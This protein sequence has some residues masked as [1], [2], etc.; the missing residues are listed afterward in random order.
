DGSLVRVFRTDPMDWSVHSDWLAKDSPRRIEE[1]IKFENETLMPKN[2]LQSAGLSG[3]IGL[4]ESFRTLQDLRFGTLMAH[5]KNTHGISAGEALDVTLA[6][7]PAALGMLSCK[8]LLVPSWGNLQCP[9]EHTVAVFPSTQA[10]LIRNPYFL[11]RFRI[12]QSVKS[13]PKIGNFSDWLSEKENQKVV[14][15]LVSFAKNHRLG[16][17][18][19]ADGDSFAWE[20]RPPEDSWESG[21]IKII[22]ETNTSIELQVESGGGL[23]VIA[24]AYD[25]DWEAYRLDDQGSS[26]RLP[27]YRANFVMR[28]IPLPSGTVT[29]RMTY[30]PR[31]IYWGAGVS[32]LGFLMA[33]GCLGI[34]RNLS[35]RGSPSS[36]EKVPR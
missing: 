17:I 14:R 29:I 35:S 18:V 23:L 12:T 33:M 25:K 10:I 24:D 9:K 21:Q 15:E 30:C 36:Q 19:E 6:P 26:T 34:G 27:V 5:L 20:P 2:H 7:D 32:F 31:G 4:V 3:S 1:I 11:D 16:A 28:G 22:Q 13:I 8:Y